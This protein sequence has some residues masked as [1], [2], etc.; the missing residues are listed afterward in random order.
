MFKSFKKLNKLKSSHRSSLFLHVFVTLLFFMDLWFGR[1]TLHTMCSFTPLNRGQVFQNAEE[2][3][4]KFG[5]DVGVESFSFYRSVGG[6][7][8]ACW[9]HMKWQTYLFLPFKFVFG[10]SWLPQSSECN[11]EVICFFKNTWSVEWIQ[12]AVGSECLRAIEK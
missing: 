4:T 7:F 12:G 3:T 8:G 6:C 2:A 11:F 5:D 10:H 1:S 9:I